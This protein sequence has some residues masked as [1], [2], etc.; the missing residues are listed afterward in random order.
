MATAITRVV[1]ES[2]PVWLQRAAGAFGA[3]HRGA[4]LAEQPAQFPGI[5]TG[6][7]EAGAE[8]HL[9]ATAD[10]RLRVSAARIRKAVPVT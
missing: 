5:G 6:G 7:G 9:D 8:A 1:V 2:C 10:D 4:G 3:I